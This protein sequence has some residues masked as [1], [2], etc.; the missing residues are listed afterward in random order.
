MR[1]LNI[2][3]YLVINRHRVEL[4][5]GTVGIEPTTMVLET[6][7]IPFNYAPKLLHYIYKRQ[8]LQ[9]YGLDIL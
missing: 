5:A 2:G 3:I 4:L 1:L 8:F 9:Y 7:V 6:I